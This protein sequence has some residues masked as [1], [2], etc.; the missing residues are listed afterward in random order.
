MAIKF[1]S[2]SA[3]TTITNAFKPN[4]RTRGTGSNMG[5]ADSLEV[6]SI[7]GQ[8]HTGSDELS[9]ILIKFPVTD[10]STDRTRTDIPA[11]GSVDFY[12]KM[13]KARHAY[14]LPKQFTLEVRPLTRDWQEGTGLDMEEYKHETLEATGANWMY[15]SNGTK[16]TRVGGD[17]KDNEFTDNNTDNGN[18]GERLYRQ[19][20]EEGTENL[21]INIT[22]AVGE[23]MSTTAATAT[24]MMDSASGITDKTLSLT[25]TDGTTHTITC[26]TA[27]TSA[28]NVDTDDISNASEFATELKAV[29]DLAVT[30]GSINMTVS[31][32]TNDS[33]G[34]P[35]VITLTQ[36]TAGAPGNTSIAGTLVS[37]NK[38]IINNTTAGGSHGTQTFTGGT[39]HVNY[40]LM[41]KLTGSQEAYHSSSNLVHN[42]GSWTSQPAVDVS[43]SGASLHNLTGSESSYYTK[44]F[45]A[46]SSEYFMKRPRIEARWD[47]SIKDDATNF[48]VSSALAPELDNVNT[49]YLYNYVRGQLQNIPAVGDSNIYVSIHT[50]S[51]RERIEAQACEVKDHTPKGGTS[52]A[53]HTFVT[54]GWVET[55]IYSASVVVTSSLSNKNYYFP[56]WQYGT[57]ETN[58][59]RAPNNRGMTTLFTGSAIEAKAFDSRQ[60]NPSRTYASSMPNLKS[61]YSRKENARLRLTARQKDWCPTIYS[62][63]K[64]EQ[65]DIEIIENA[66]F[67]AYRVV[68][69][70]EVVPY[71]T[72]SNSPQADGSAGSYTRLSFDA[73]GSYFDLDMSIFEPGYS[74]AFKFVYYDNGTYKEQPEIFKFRVEE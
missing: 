3:D 15:A 70:F 13:T 25:N 23:W 73:S 50:G 48:Y 26:T 20:F 5:F 34:N 47:S 16:W 65:Q 19:S 27:A 59:G 4:L 14:T 52:Q 17:F 35:R 21:E 42:N 11:S 53:F 30:A 18:S 41:I 10:I 62:V 36:V 45:F 58:A 9:R 57:E 55:G 37:N 44:K 64:K 68:D 38:V 40:G 69:D 61:T 8:A 46:R 51:S 63:A 56:V 32:V 7:Y 72:G 39:G 28:T 43:D 54:G 1:Y 22:E 24:I 74:Y 29:L 66:Y 67:K 33:G 2:A 71:G 49:I 12:L 31:S 6:F 60:G